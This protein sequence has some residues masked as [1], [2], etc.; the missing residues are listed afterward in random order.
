MPVLSWIDRPHFLQQEFIFPK[1]L[2]QNAILMF[3]PPSS[4]VL[5]LKHQFVG[6]TKQR[7]GEES[8]DLTETCK[9]GE[10]PRCG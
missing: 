3:N 7:Q 1:Q 2:C 4:S 6:K 8:T 10:T 5:A 9:S